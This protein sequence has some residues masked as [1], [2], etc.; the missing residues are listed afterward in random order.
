MGGLYCAFTYILLSVV[1]NY[2]KYRTFSLHL[3]IKIALTKAQAI[4]TL[5][6]IQTLG[7][8]SCMQVYYYYTHST[9]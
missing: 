8:I 4:I 2:N 5:S 6:S 3:R 1:Y 7:P 9:I